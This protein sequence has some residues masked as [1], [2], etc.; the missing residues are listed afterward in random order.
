MGR[1]SKLSK[2]QRALNT[3]FENEEIDHDLLD[4]DDDDQEASVDGGGGLTEPQNRS[5]RVQNSSAHLTN[6]VTIQNLIKTSTSKLLASDEDASKLMAHTSYVNIYLNSRMQTDLIVL[7]MLRDRSYQLYTEKNFCRDLDRAKAM[8]R[9]GVKN[10]PGDELTFTEVWPSLNTYMTARFQE[11]YEYTQSLPGIDRIS[12]RDLFALLGNSYIML[13]ALFV[14]RTF[15]NDQ[16]YIWLPGGIQLTRRL[17]EALCTKELSD[18]IY[19]FHAKI[20]RIGVT[21]QELGLLTPVV[22]TMNTGMSIKRFLIFNISNCLDF[23][24]FR[25]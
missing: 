4:D 19:E 1:I 13:S 10:F 17:M 24:S 5:R 22:L 6:L 15:I 3:E 20:A 16:S 18:L 8:V 9:M 12:R 2:E 14:T 23:G 21:D 7:N 25:C 11:F